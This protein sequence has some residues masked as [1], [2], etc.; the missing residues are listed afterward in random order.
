MTFLRPLLLACALTGCGV[1]ADA[2]PDGLD[3]DVEA[4]DLVQVTEID[5]PGVTFRVAQMGRFSDVGLRPA[6]GGHVE[7]ARGA[8]LLAMGETLELAVAA[9]A[10][11]AMTDGTR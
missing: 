10:A 7:T 11:S 3:F 6:S 9:L 4:G 2:P 5:G 8:V 1:L